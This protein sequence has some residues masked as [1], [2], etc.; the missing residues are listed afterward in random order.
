MICDSTLRSSEEYLT[1]FSQPDLGWSTQDEQA[2][3]RYYSRH[4]CQNFIKEF[5]NKKLTATLRQAMKQN[6]KSKFLTR[7]DHI[8]EKCPGVATWLEDISRDPNDV[9]RNNRP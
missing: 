1:G 8:R 4:I 3:H 6:Q 7:L 2:F 9:D 5:T